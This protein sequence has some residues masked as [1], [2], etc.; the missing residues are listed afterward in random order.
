MVNISKPLY[1]IEYDEPIWVSQQ[2]TLDVIKTVQLVEQFCGGD[3]LVYASRF[4]SIY[5]CFF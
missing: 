1:L 2:D 3:I 5:W 4:C